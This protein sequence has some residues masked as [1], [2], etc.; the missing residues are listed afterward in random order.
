MGPVAG[1]ALD[2]H[3]RR[4]L[5]RPF[6]VVG[7]ARRDSGRR[8]DCRGECG[9]RRSPSIPAGV[10]WLVRRRTAP[11]KSGRWTTSPG[12]SRRRPIPG[13][14]CASASVPMG[15]SSPRAALTGWPAVGRRRPRGDEAAPSRLVRTVSFSPDGGYLATGCDDQSARI[16]E[17]ASQQTVA[18]LPHGFWVRTVAFSPDGRHLATCADD[19]PGQVW[20]WADERPLVA[21]PDSTGEGRAIAFRPRWA[22]A[23]GLRRRDGAE[24]WTPQTR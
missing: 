5:S 13:R 3:P 4:E 15:G 21:I 10:T 17:V 24:I 20:T 9:R 12:R 6:K 19:H 22:R 1:A 8:V 11:P 16:W 23:A 18:T 7:L 14:C 2:G